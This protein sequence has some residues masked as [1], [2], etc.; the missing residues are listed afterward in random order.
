MKVFN[1]ENVSH[2]SAYSHHFTSVYVT[3][4]A[5]QLIDDFLGF[6]FF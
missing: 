4:L 6:F 5:V 1:R 2:F 3:V